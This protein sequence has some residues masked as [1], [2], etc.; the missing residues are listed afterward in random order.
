MKLRFGIVCFS[1]LAT[2]FA[3]AQD[4]KSILLIN[5]FLHKGNGEIL[6]T[7]LIGVRS[8]R[9]EMV[10][11]SLATSYKREEWDTIIDLQGKHI[12]PGFIAPNSTLG[13]TEIDAVRATR[14][15]D[16]VGIYN[17]HVRS[18]IAFNVESK[19]ISTVRTNGVLICQATPRGGSISGTSAVMLMDGWNWEDATVSSDDG[20]HVN[21][22]SSAEGGGWWAE[23]SPKKR[24]EKYEDQKAELIN[25]FSD[26]KAYCDGGKKVDLDLRFNAMRDCFKGEKRVYFHAND[27]QQLLDVID[28]VRKFELPFPVIVGGYDSH[29]IAD[30]LKEDKIPV[31]IG[32]VHSLPEYEEDPIDQPFSL[33]AQLH[34]AGVKCCIQNSGDMEAMNARNLPFQAGTCIAYG[35]PAEEA[36]KSLTLNTAEIIGINKDYGSIEEGKSA[37]LFVSDGDALDMRSNNVS[38]AMINGKF[39]SLDNSQKQLYKKYHNKYQKK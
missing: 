10:R 38:L 20:I 3:Q 35:L 39:M 5:G 17:P 13:L 16:E 24:N 8:G 7:A 15:F 30:R 12:Y 6:E 32:R 27:V 18:Q 29:L 4:Q 9:I 28:F 19:V 2:F 14:D 25:F 21:W 34:A 1:L 37:T 22:P 11:N 31:M 33:A 23:P 26:A 36:V